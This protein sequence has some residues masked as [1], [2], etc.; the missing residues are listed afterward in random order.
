ME[1][2]AEMYRLVKLFTLLGWGIATGVE[3]VEKLGLIE[4]LAHP[5]QEVIEVLSAL[6]QLVSLSEWM[7]EETN[8]LLESIF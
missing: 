3:I 7:Q 1:P 4:V 2:T 6:N 8:N 5:Q